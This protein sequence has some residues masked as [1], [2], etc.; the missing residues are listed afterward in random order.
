MNY[1]LTVKLFL[2]YWFSPWKVV[3]LKQTAKILFKPFQKTFKASKGLFTNYVDKILAFSDHLPPCVE[4]F[5]GTIVD[6]KTT[7]LPTS[8][9]KHSL[10]AT[11]KCQPKKLSLGCTFN[12]WI[13]SGRGTTW[14]CTGCLHMGTQPTTQTPL[15]LLH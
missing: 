13:L 2:P 12:F 4:I 10:R 1:P 6:K 9:C 5:Y 14:L 15:S 3:W 7:Y 8:S 11:P